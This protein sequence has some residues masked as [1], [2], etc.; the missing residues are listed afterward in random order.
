MAQIPNSANTPAWLREDDLEDVVPLNTLPPSSSGAAAPSN[1]PD[2]Q[3]QLL[4]VHYALK[5]VTMLLCILMA[6]TAIIGVDA[7]SKIFVIVYMLFFSVLLLV[8]EAI[9]LR[10]I[11]WID[12]L[13]RRNFGF[14]YKAMGKAFFIIFIAF[15]SFG[16][17]EPQGLTYATGSAWALFGFLEV[18]LYLKYPELFE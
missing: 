1:S 9:E 8:F 2:G 14:M 18:G 5:G 16:L 6:A 15:L 10:R 7:V 11:D 4:T 13:F 3:K 17:G 12:H